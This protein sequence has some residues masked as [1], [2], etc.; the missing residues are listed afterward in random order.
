[1]SNL[2]ALTEVAEIQRIEAEYRQ[3][4]SQYRQ[5]FGLSRAMEVNNKLQDRHWWSEKGHAEFVLDLISD[6]KREL[7]N[8]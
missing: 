4:L 5:R 1:M 6:M 8:E 3:T 7:G 2:T